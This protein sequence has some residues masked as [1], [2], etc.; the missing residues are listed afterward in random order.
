MGVRTRVVGLATALLVALVISAPAQAAFPGQNGKIA[1]SSARDGGG[2]AKEIYS[3]NPD[4]SVQTRLT[5][6]D[7]DNNV[8]VWSPDGSRIAFTSTRGPS[9]IW[10][11]NADGSGQSLLIPGGA[12]PAWSPDGG[13]IAFDRRV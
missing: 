8:P 12:G 11:M 5:S 9:G 4:G 2:T 10:V 1:F 6:S 7:G 13:R 3:M